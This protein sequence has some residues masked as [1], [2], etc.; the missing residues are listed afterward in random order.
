MSYAV[1]IPGAFHLCC[2]KCNGHRATLS[3]AHAT[4]SRIVYADPMPTPDKPNWSRFRPF[5]DPREAG[6]LHA[7]FGPGVYDLRRISTGKPVLYGIG[8]RCAQRMTSLLPKPLGNGTRNNE[9]KR[10]YLLRH[11]NDIE[12]RTCA[13]KTREE[14]ADIERS[15]R[16]TR[17]HLYTFNT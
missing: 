14:A 13:C 12:Y 11:I 6:I 2:A 7:P 4:T 5:P 1:A 3:H 17:G 16:H 10:N 8:S 9:R 15:I